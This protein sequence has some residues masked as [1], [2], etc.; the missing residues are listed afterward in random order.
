MDAHRF[1]A[2][3]RLVATSLPRRQLV[4]VLVAAVLAPPGGARSARRN[5]PARAAVHPAVDCRDP[6]IC[7]ASR[8]DGGQCQCDAAACVAAG[9]C[10]QGGL[11]C[12]SPTMC[13]QPGASGPG[14]LALDCGG[15]NGFVLPCPD[16]ADPSSCGRC[17]D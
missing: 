5:G 12:A 17:V 4:T 13:C 11:C 8:C 1:D 6:A 15:P 9:G 10:C 14:C 16:P 2:L 3:A 7:A